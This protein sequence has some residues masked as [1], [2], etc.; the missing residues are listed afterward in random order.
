MTAFP[1]RRPQSSMFKKRASY[2]TQTEDVAHSEVATDRGTTEQMFLNPNEG[3]QSI[4]NL[5]T[6]D[7]T[8]FFEYLRSHR[9]MVVKP[10]LRIAHISDTESR[11]S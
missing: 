2:Q 1:V 5:K 10:P 9:D 11:L 6:K 3:I 8:D 7:A 4:M